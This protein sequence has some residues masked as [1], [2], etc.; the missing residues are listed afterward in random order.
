MKKVLLQI[1]ILLSC[2]ALLAQNL[3]PNGSFE[4]FNNCPNNIPSGIIYPIRIA[5]SPNYD[6]FPTVKNWIT[7]LWQDQAGYFNTCNNLP[8]DMGVPSNGAGFQQP[9]SGNAYIGLY[10]F[11]FKNHAQWDYRQYVENKLLHPLTAN[12]QYKISFYISLAASYTL[13]GKMISV[14]KIGAYLSDTM[15]H[16]SF[17]SLNHYL[18]LKPSLKSTPEW[19]I[20]DT[21]NWTK[22]E[23][24][25]TAHGGEQWITLGH[26]MDGEPQNEKYLYAFD[27]TDIYDSARYC[28]MYIDDVCVTDI[29]DNTTDTA[30][31]AASFPIALHTATIPGDCLWSTGAA[32]QSITITAPGTYWRQVTGDCL[33][34]T[35]T[36]RVAAMPSSGLGTITNI[37]PGTE[38]TLGIEQ[39]NTSFLWSNGDTQCCVTTGAPGRYALTVSNICGTISDSTELTAAPCENCLIAPNAFTPNDDGRNDRFHIIPRC[40]I[41]GFHISIYN[42]WGQQLYQSTDISDGWDGTYSGTAQEVGTYVYYIEYSFATQ[43]GTKKEIMKGDVILVR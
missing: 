43:T 24:T 20:T 14:D 34:H 17:S 25:Y 30:F 1:A 5:Y 18:S 28:Y 27:S 36:F 16:D 3:V 42:R 32:S 13:S 31:C 11:V 21:T 15:V 8:D 6:S 10:M 7:P 26:F 19:F 9:H 29:T 33:Y 23:G 2:N 39:P 41:G 37:C 38:V 12:R 40:S 22:I 4:E 35:D